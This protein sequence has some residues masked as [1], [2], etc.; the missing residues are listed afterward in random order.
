MHIINVSRNAPPETAARLAAIHAAAFNQAH[1]RPWDEKTF[2]DYLDQSR[3]IILAGFDT[4]EENQESRLNACCGFIV[5]QK[6]ADGLEDGPAAEAEIL[7]LA[8]H[9]EWQRRGVAQALLTAV[10]QYV[11]GILF[12]EVAADNQPALALY[13]NCGFEES[14]RRRAY[15]RRTAQHSQAGGADARVDAILMQAVFSPRVC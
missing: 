2:S 12:L 6:L 15:Y 4:A 8:V 7:T 3:V 1:D 13:Q 9:P 5:L 11:G 14:G 10:E